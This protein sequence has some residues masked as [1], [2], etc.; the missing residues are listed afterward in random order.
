MRPL[1][2]RLNFP[3]PNTCCSFHP[4]CFVPGIPSA[5]NAFPYSLKATYSTKFFCDLFSKM[6]FPF[7]TSEILGCFLL[8]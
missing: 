7:A 1:N 5:W 2:N 4:P 3:F 6:S 8:P